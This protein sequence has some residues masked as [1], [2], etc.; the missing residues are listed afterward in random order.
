MHQFPVKA[1]F[2]DQWDAEASNVFL[3]FSECGLSWRAMLNPHNEHRI[4]FTRLL[5][6]D[7]VLAN[8]QWDPRLGQ[9]VNA[10]MHATTAVLVATI[11]WLAGGRRRVDLIVFLCAVTF[12][13]PFAWE[14]ILFAFQSPFYFLVLF[15]VLA[16]WLTTRS[17]AL[18]PAWFIGWACAVGGLF[19]AASGVLIP[20]AI[21]SIVALK[22]ANEPRAWRDSAANVATAGLV[23][24][25]GAAI[26]SPP[27]AQHEPLRAHSI[28][29]LGIALARALSWPWVDRPELMFVMW[30]PLG[31]LT[32]VL[33]LRR[34]KT[35]ELERLVVGLAVWVAFHAGAVAYGR[36]AGGATP[37]TRYMDFLSLGFVAN[38]MALLAALD[39]NLPGIPPTAC[40][41]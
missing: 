24:A 8:G 2:W 39:W 34:G 40:G 33:I 41:G 29:E 13:L 37:A 1:P 20:V 6:L 25:G 3:P 21:V 31:V 26:A 12:A 18:G 36:G 14:N 27:L 16:L 5:A 22:V 15:S 10:A 17:R 23:L 11:F 9:V 28:T 4:F 7:L 35:T 38:G 30:L 19:T 32:L